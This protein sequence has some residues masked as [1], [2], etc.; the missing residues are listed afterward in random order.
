MQTQIIMAAVGGLAIA[1]AIGVNIMTLE[2]EV[3]EKSS[4]VINEQ[5]SPIP[6]QSAPE[7]QIKKE[8]PVAQD[9]TGTNLIAAPQPTQTEVT[10]EAEPE[11]IVQK[12]PASKK[13]ESNEPEQRQPLKPVF[14]IVRIT[15][16]GDAVIAGK[17]EPNSMVTIYDDKK[18]I[19]AVKADHRGEWVFVPNTP[20]S[21]G[22]RQLSL[23]S[24]V[25]G[26][27]SFPSDDVV[28]LVVPEPK[29]DIAGRKSDKPAQALALKIPNTG[30]PSTILQK[31][32]SEA[33]SRSLNVDIID[34]DQSGKLLISG[35]A[36]AN[37]KIFAYLTN[38]FIGQT[39]TA[40]S[41]TWR[42]SPNRSIDPGLYTLRVD[43]VDVDG[44][45][46][47]RI[48]MPFSRAEPMK[49]APPEPFIVVQPG[50][51]LWRLATRTYGTGMHYT[52]IFEANRDQIKDPDLIFPGQI[53]AIPTN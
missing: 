18:I 28:V 4:P 34:Y 27:K 31:P 14:D 41:G 46:I 9:Q 39:L 15:P 53:F 30:G 22:S 37:D 20:F 6:D 13:A 35:R 7:A 33:D 50:N 5:S 8:V 51:S 1:T 42:L 12:Q 21:P 26:G 17:A 32:V 38:E 24:D 3:A 49:E 25:S 47:E 19:G 36:K 23:R 11:V 44:K 45:V 16:N 48:S 2:E 52:T 29:K 40:K 10:T 43:H